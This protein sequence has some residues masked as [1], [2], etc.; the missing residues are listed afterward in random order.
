MCNKLH[1]QKMH[2]PLFLSLYTQTKTSPRAGKISRCFTV[3]RNSQIESEKTETLGARWFY[4]LEL[5]ASSLTQRTSSNGLLFLSR[6]IFLEKFS[7]KLSN[8]F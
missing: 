6:K 5:F 2:S 8:F 7:S 3:F 1:N 4:F